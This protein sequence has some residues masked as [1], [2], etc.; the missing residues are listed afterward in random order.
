[1]FWMTRETVLGLFGE[2]YMAF[3]LFGPVHLF[4]LLLTAV[5]TFLIFRYFPG[6]NKNTRKKLYITVTV[7]L[8]IDELFKDFGSL[9]TGQFIFE[10]LPF[11]LCSVNIFVC[12]LNTIKEDDRYKAILSCV[13]IPAAFCALFMPNWTALPLLNFMHL[14]SETVHILLFI[15]PMMILSE[16][17]RPGLNDMKTIFIYI[18]SLASLDKVLNHFLGTNFLFLTHNENNPA[19]II[20]ENVFGRFYNLGIVLGI[21]LLTFVMVLIWNIIKVH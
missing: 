15:Y 11:H 20:L 14:H 10:C 5:L 18:V 19:L 21:S 2:D 16:G 17:Y 9:L 12:I 1:M 4:W 7:L 8:I 6:L 3:K 13:C